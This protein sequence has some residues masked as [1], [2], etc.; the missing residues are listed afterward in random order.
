MATTQTKTNGTVDPFDAEAAATE[1]TKTTLKA[2]EDA[3]ELYGKTVDQL[4]DVHVEVAE[5]TKLPA[6]VTIAETQA[7]VGREVAGTYVT[8]VRDLLKA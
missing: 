1:L 3:L 2:T 5:A 7:A 8:V 6:L 4:A